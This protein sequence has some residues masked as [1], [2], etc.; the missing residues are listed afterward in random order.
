MRLDAASGA[1]DQS[2]RFQAQPRRLL[3]DRDRV[4]FLGDTVSLN[5]EYRAHL[6]AVDRRSGA[7]SPWNPLGLFP[8]FPEGSP[9]VTAAAVL[10][11]L[12]V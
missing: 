5:G 10:R 6:F 2:W 8:S 7:L 3:F 4:F 12:D 9:I 1:V 11:H